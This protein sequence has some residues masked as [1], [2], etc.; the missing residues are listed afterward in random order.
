MFGVKCGQYWL[1]LHRLSTMDSNDTWAVMEL[2]A[3]VE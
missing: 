2:Y 3:N 1:L